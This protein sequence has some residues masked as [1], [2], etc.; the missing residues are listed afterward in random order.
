MKKLFV[1]GN[2]GSDAQMKTVKDDEVMSFS[3][4]VNEKRRDLP[5]VHF[6]V[7]N[8]RKDENLLR[9]LKKGT[10][11]NVVGE[12]TVN[13]YGERQAFGIIAAD[14]EIIQKPASA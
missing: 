3:V 13:T 12:F 4:L 5:P 6:S 11:V 8:Y 9:L 10:R 1:S 14:V 2:L 7:L